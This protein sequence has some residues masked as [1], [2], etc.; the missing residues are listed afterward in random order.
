MVTNR[1]KHLTLGQQTSK[2]CLI[3]ATHELVV[4]QELLVK[5]TTK[6]S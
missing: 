5:T 3:R 1:S 2:Q 6:I 4:K